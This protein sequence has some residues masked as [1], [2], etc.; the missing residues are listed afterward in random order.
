MQLFFKITVSFSL[1]FLFLQC[2]PS[3]TAEAQVGQ[4]AL[5][6]GTDEWPP[7]EFAGPD[8]SVR[9]LA[10]EIV[11][12]VCRRM[13]ESVA[14]IAQYPWSRGL[15]ML[16]AGSLDV[17]YAGV[18]DP[19]R[20]D[21]VRY[22]KEPLVESRW[23]LFSRREGGERLVYSSLSDLD[24]HLLGVVRRYSYTPEIDS[25]LAR[26]KEVVEVSSD[27]DNLELLVRGRVEYALCDVL[28][29]RFV[30]ERIGIADLVV[31]VEG[32]ALASA[33]IYALFSRKTVSASFVER[34]DAGLRAFKLSSEYGA[35]LRRH[36]N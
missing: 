3:C 19:T 14:S 2:V 13:G 33:P 11:T 9:G 16:E 35:I 29:C 15:K 21:F 18:F 32:P 34:F 28:N 30:A 6:V 27:E 24:G 4:R 36:L 5:V 12:E 17:L 31:Q 25:Y 22:H 26:H 1:C 10:T 7:Y 20:L 8:G 23:V